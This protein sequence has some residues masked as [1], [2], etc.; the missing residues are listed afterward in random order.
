V[1]TRT[2]KHAAATCAL[3]IIA[4][5]LPPPCSSDTLTITEDDWDAVP[6]LEPVWI[7]EVCGDSAF[8]IRNGFADPDSLLAGMK[9]FPVPTLRVDKNYRVET[10]DSRGARISK[11][12]RT[13]YVT[14]RP[15]G[16][17]MKAEIN[18]NRGVETNGDAMQGKGEMVGI[19]WTDRVAVFRSGGNTDVRDGS[20][21]LLT[22]IPYEAMRCRFFD[23]QERIVLL[24]GDVVR[25]DGGSISLHK[26]LV[27]N[28]AGEVIFEGD[29]SE[30]AVDWIGMGLDTN[31]LQIEL[32]GCPR[33]GD[34]LLRIDEGKV[35]SLG[36][37]PKRGRRFAIDYS[38][39][40]VN[41]LGEFSFYAA[42]N[43][44][45]P[46]LIWQRDIGRDIQAVAVSAEGAFVAYRTG[47][48]HEGRSHLRVVSGVDGKPLCRLAH[49]FDQPVFDPLAFS[50]FYLFAGTGFGWHLPSSHTEHICVYDLSAMKPDR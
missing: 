47:T 4:I 27:L 42:A 17:L 3:A 40:L 20:G 50:G 32:V 46:Q 41:R 36:T 25:R 7:L 29:W 6:E 22:R 38:H 39:V 11:A 19:S 18:W 9:Q 48:E 35:Y 21:S 26:T 5:G 31:I 23:R 33:A 16:T 15:D 13:G 10:D 28:F 45:S 24:A 44:E 2:I 49:Q 1:S 34:Y 37:L 8:V 30:C 14:I 12:T 43:P